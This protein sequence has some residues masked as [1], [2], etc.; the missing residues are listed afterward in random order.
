MGFIKFYAAVFREALRHSLDLAQGAIFLALIIGGAFATGNP[1]AK[2]ILDQMQLG[3]WL[4]GAIAL[5][6]IVLLRL[7]WAP[8]WLYE[9]ANAR[10]IETPALSIDF[11][12]RVEGFKV[13]TGEF[14]QVNFSL[15][16]TLSVAL[17]YVVEEI[18][19]ILD[20]KVIENVTIDGGKY[21]VGAKSSTEAEFPAFPIDTRKKTVTGSGRI[22]YKFGQAGSIFTRRATYAATLTINAER[23]RHRVMEDD[24][25]SI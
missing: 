18:C 21:I 9:R 10:N 1:R 17:Q 19:V 7:L 8:Y 25:T 11:G 4:A 22:V 3:G 24:E 13:S 16:N 20:D 5:G 23:Y 14:T 12:L 2:G 15:Q 6:L